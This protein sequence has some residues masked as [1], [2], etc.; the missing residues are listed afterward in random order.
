[1]NKIL[2][3]IA[4]LLLF[5][6]AISGCNSPLAGKS[7]P[8]VITNT[9]DQTVYVA[10][11]QNGVRS[12]HTLEMGKSYELPL[13]YYTPSYQAVQSE[14]STDIDDRF[15]FTRGVDYFETKIVMP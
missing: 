15:S 3:L 11:T 10:I 5:A 9:T 2:V 8:F 4:A 7:G 14:S 6:V 1:M 12:V 13:Y